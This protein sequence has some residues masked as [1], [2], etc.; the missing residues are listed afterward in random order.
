MHAVISMKFLTTLRTAYLV[1]DDQIVAPDQGDQ[2]VQFHRGKV[3]ALG[4]CAEV[5]LDE[6]EAESLHGGVAG[7][8]GELA[9]AHQLAPLAGRGD[10][11]RHVVQTC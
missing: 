9:P 8:A 7:G 10:V 6:V 2:E 1:R 5:G 4:D 11:D 3:G